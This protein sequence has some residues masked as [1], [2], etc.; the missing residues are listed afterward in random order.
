VGSI[1]A[2]DG[3]AGGFVGLQPLGQAT[4]DP[5]GNLADH[6]VAAAPVTVAVEAER[7]QFVLAGRTAQG[8]GGGSHVAVVEVVQGR[9]DFAFDPRLVVVDGLGASRLGEGDDGDAVGP[10]AILALAVGESAA[11]VGGDEGRRD[12]VHPG[13]IVQ[14]SGQPISRSVSTGVSRRTDGPSN[15]VWSL[16]VERLRL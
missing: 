15:R 13:T 4:A 6:T 7:E 2:P 1:Q 12:P 10:A 11:R 16:P 14:P 8:E 3:N 9:G 5:L